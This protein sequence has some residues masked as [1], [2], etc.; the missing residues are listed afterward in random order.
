MKTHSRHAF[1]L[2]ELLTVIAIIG[3]LAAIIIPVTASVRESAKTAKCGASQRQIA[4]AVI[5]Y[6]GANRDFLPGPVNRDVHA[7][8]LGGPPT[9]SLRDFIQPYIGDKSDSFWRCPSNDA[10][11][12][13]TGDPARQP[14]YFLNR[15]ATSSPRDF[16]GV[17]GSSDVTRQVKRLSQIK[18]ADATFAVEM[19]LSRIWMMTD[20]DSRNFGNSYL[21]GLKVPPPHKEGRNYVF[22]DGHVAYIKVPG[23]VG[24][25]GLLANPIG[26]PDYSL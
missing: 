1:T 4:L 10:A 9:D 2:I 5:L 26:V 12:L 24:A 6:A 3:I 19:P 21:G 8:P 22:F 17:P 18:S 11:F 20:I 13:A 23:T 15:G 7:P 14:I 16:F 25:G